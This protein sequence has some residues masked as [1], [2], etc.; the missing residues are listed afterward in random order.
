MNDRIEINYGVLPIGARYW[1]GKGDDSPCLTKSEA[2][3]AYP[4]PV[5]RVWVDADAHDVPIESGEVERTSIEYRRL[6][7]GQSFWIRRRG[8]QEW[9]RGMIPNESAFLVVWIEIENSE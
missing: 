4:K 5:P 7:C 9:R 1:R 2:G 6:R 8:G 3:A